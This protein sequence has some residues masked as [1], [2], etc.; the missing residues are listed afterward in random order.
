M[1]EWAKFNE[2]HPWGRDGVAIT[3]KTITD[4]AEL[5]DAVRAKQ[6]GVATPEQEA[7]VMGTDLLVQQLLDE[8]PRRS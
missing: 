2:K 6:N 7:I 1:A 5:R 3:G 8:L 4:G